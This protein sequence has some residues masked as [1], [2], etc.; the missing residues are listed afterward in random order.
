MRS[1]GSRLPDRTAAPIRP[2]APEQT[3]S[4]ERPGGPPRLALAG[5]RP[6]WRERQA[7]KEAEGAASGPPPAAPPTDIATDEV[8]MP[9]KKTGGYVP[10]ARRGIDGASAPRGRTDA[11]PTSAPPRDASSSI[12]PTAKWRPSG[13]RDGMGRDGSPADAPLRRNLDG[14][15]RT[16]A[17][18]DSSPADGGRP[19][20][21]SGTA[22]TESPAAE[23]SRPAQAAKYV[24]M[25]MRNK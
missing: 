16:G 4:S 10:P 18:R 20:S 7:A 24:P 2:S 15:R 23:T 13:A 12:E 5:N 14:L 25:H 19:V 21:S 6:T 1:G 3:P 11:A 17:D 9:L 8:S 22:R